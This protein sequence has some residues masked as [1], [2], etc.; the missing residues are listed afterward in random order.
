[1][2]NT[3]EPRTPRRTVLLTGFE[4][5]DGHEINP[6]QKIV[7]QLNGTWL[8]DE[9]QVIGMVL[10]VVFGEDTKRV[11]PA[12]AEWKPVAVLSLGLHAGAKSMEVEMFAVNHR[13]GEGSSLTPI[14]EEGP[15][16]YFA[17]I[18]VDKVGKAIGDT[19]VPVTRHGYAGSYLCNHVFY[20]TAHLTATQGLG[21]AVGFLHIPLATEQLTGD[22]ETPAP[23]LPL[24]KMVAAVRAALI[25]AIP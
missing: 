23:S 18:D 22:T 4:P 2:S 8:D 7:E 17:T 5:F 3:A 1:M 14:L 10:P 13:R 9:T 20:Q 11:F 16:A 24:D 21:C 12:I 15:A 6:S 19:E 25:A